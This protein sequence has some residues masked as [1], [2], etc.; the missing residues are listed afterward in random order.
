MLSKIENN[1]FYLYL[2]DYRTP[3]A[4]VFIGQDR[5]EE[6]AFKSN[7]YENCLKGLDIAITIPPDVYSLT[8][9]FW[10]GLLSNCI[11]HLKDKET[12]NNKIVIIDESNT[13]SQEE[14]DAL[15]HRVLTLNN[16]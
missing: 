3:N 5:G 14:I 2:E 6:I 4:K 10:R 9:G 11:K 12:I 7:I 13:R 1:T 15:I 8:Y 16:L